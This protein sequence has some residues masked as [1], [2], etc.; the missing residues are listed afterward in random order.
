MSE[1]AAE[2]DGRS[3]YFAWTKEL[4]DAQAV[5]KEK[6]EAR[7]LAI[8]TVSG[9]LVSLLFGLSALATRASA[10]YFLPSGARSYLY[11]ALVF[12]V[13]SALL[14]ILT[15]LPMTY[16][17]V[18]QAGLRAIVSNAYWTD[19]EREAQQRVAVTRVNVLLWNRR[20]NSVKAYVPVGA[21]LFQIAA[22]VF[23]ALAVFDVLS[24][25][26]TTPD[27]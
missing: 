19:T 22:V 8:I 25:A 11:V 9:A 23:V 21:I 10:G 14:A 4:T 24:A 18:A 5:R 1:P 26:P 12:F 7:G 15:N 20:V 17:E 2:A 6:L 3:V 27:Q 13:V 16:R